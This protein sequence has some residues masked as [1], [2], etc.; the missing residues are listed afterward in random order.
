MFVRATCVHTCAMH[1][2]MSKFYVSI[3]HTSKI[4]RKKEIDSEC[5]SGQVG[6]KER[7]R[8]GDSDRERAGN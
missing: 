4:S 8:N 7:A 5:K 6:G 2:N 1:E 3:R